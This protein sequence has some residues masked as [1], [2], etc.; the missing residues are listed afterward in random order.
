MPNRELNR[1]SGVQTRSRNAPQTIQPVQSKDLEC[2]TEIQTSQQQTGGAASLLVSNAKEKNNDNNDED[3]R[4]RNIVSAVISARNATIFSNLDDRISLLLEQKLEAAM[5]NLFERLNLNSQPAQ[6]AVNR[7]PDASVPQINMPRNNSTPV[8]PTDANNFAINQ[9]FPNQIDQFRFSNI[10]SVPNSGRVAQLISNWDIKFDGSPKLSVDSFL[11]RIECQV[12]DTLCGNYNLLCEHIQSLFLNEAKDWYWRY[13]RTIERVTWPSLCEALRTNFQQ[14]KTDFEIKEIVRSRKQGQ[15]ECFD[16]FRNAVIKLAEPLQTP[17]TESELIEIL[18]YNL[19]PRI[20]QQLLYVQINS[21]AELRRLCLK[22]ESLINEINKPTNSMANTNLRPQP[23]RYINDLKAE[24]NLLAS[25]EIE[26]EI[27]EISKQSAK[28]KQVCWN[29]RREGHRKK[30]FNTD[31]KSTTYR[32][33]SDRCKH[34]WKRVKKNRKILNRLICSTEHKTFDIR[35][36]AK[37]TILDSEHL[38][39]LDSGAQVS[40]LGSSL[41]N[42]VCKQKKLRKHTISICTAD[43]K[44][45][46]V[47]GTIDLNVQFEDKNEV[48]KFFVVPSMSQNVILGVDFW[49][50]FKIAPHIISEISLEPTLDENSIILSIEQQ[51]K[52]DLVKNKFPSFE[53]EGLG[54]TSLMEYAI[55]L[56]PNVRPIKQRYFPISPAVEKLVHAEIDEMIKLSVIEE[57]P[58]SPWSSPVVLVKKP[59]KVRLCL[60]S[61]KI[62]SVTV[63]DAYPLPHIDGILSRI[64]KAEYISSLDLRR[65]FWQIPL[66]E[67]SRDYTCF[68]VPN[69]PLYRYRVMPFGLCNAPQA[70]CRL[71]DRVIPPQLK[72]QVFVY[73]DDL[74]IVSAS[75]D[76]HMSILAEVAHELRRAG[77]TIN[78]GKSKFCIREVKYLGYIVGNG[79]L[80]TDPDKISAVSNYPVPTSVKLLRRFLGMAGWYRRFVDNFAAVATPLTNLLK[81]SKNFSWNDEAQ[82]SLDTLKQMLCTAPVLASPNYEKPFIIQCDASKLGVGAVLAQKNIDGIEVPIAY[83][84]QKLNKAQTNYSVTEL[85]CLA[86]ILSLKKF[87]AYVEGQDF[88]IVTDHAS[89][90]WLM[91]QTDLSSRL[92]RWSLKLQGYRFK[93]EHRKGTLNIVPDSLSRQN[94]DE[95][96][97]L[98]VL[99]LVDLHSSEFLSEEYKKLIRFVQENGESLPDLQIIDGHLYKRTEHP[100]GDPD[101]E[102]FN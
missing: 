61:R 59:N 101:R 33:S 63:K 29:C 91:H 55:E 38:G 4:I 51:R 78:V 25:P 8:W 77:L 40:C 31:N 64:P 50:K 75:F 34:F 100:N 49:I 60:D 95:I 65:A 102:A 32:R 71:M 44:K 66:A 39:L 80:R 26:I 73:L 53:K 74:L 45:Q 5:T 93:I 16:D 18:Q 94:F 46:I 19:R 68:T 14:H 67:S 72:T 43:G 99:P 87:R 11:Y 96:A 22:G 23:R 15:Y 88:T 17:F 56:E 13:R 10:S 85:E 1:N 58:N 92:A 98:E 47:Y 3:N 9:D 41:A 97:S 90:E 54:K 30:I 6:P 21:L 42:D 36:Y 69:R 86:A 57:A 79:T 70:L 7:S 24:D 52:L 89:L 84:S 48:I 82:K 62:N 37:I 35:P 28:T 2:P 83:F 76:D 20:R 12:T 27:D 81:K